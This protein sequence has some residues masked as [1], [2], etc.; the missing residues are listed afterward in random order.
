VGL[1]E[2]STYNADASS[3][4]KWVGALVSLAPG[5]SLLR[6]LATLLP[7]SDNVVAPPARTAPV[8]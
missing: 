4:W 8:V 3:P 2:F 6:W 1:P 7:G 5:L